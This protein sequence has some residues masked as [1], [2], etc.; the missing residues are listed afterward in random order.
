VL[1]RQPAISAPRFNAST[2][3]PLSDPKL[4]PETLTTDAGR[5]AFGLRRKDP[6]VFA[7]GIRKCGS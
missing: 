5:N 3:G 1:C 4:M 7:H 6:S 2:A